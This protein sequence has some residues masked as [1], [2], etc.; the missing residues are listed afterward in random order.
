MKKRTLPSGCQIFLGIFASIIFG[1]IGYFLY[2]N[3]WY[4]QVQAELPEIQQKLVDINYETLEQFPPPPGLS[5]IGRVDWI[6]QYDVESAIEYKIVDPEVEI[7][8]YYSAL[9][10]E[11][12]W[13]RGGGNSV[14]SEVVSYYKDSTC[15]S[16]RVF[17]RESFV[18]ARTDFLKQEFVPELPPLWYRK[19]RG[20]DSGIKSCP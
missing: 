20:E 15:I 3:H 13:T 16:I 19:L 18:S 10:D 8:N 6:D 5:E 11:A 17:F 2:L 14:G 4:N 9:L 1:L 12:G 7:V